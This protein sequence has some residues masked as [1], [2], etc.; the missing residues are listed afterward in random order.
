MSAFV[1]PQL[2]G[3]ANLNTT[4]RY[5]H[6]K[7]ERITREFFSVMEYISQTLGRLQIEVITRITNVARH[8]MPCH[9]SFERRIMENDKT[10]N[11]TR[12]ELAET[13]KRAFWSGYLYAVLSGARLRRCDPE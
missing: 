6:M 4:Q 12:E 13:V 9:S 3:H 10:G 5:F 1:L 7:E 8:K 2:L 11:N